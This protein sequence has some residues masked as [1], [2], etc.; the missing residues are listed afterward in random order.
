MEL[1]NLKV[2]GTLGTE[3][4]FV[5]CSSSSSSG[6]E[7]QI[8]VRQST[9]QTNNSN[10]PTTSSGTEQVRVWRD[11]SLILESEPNVRHIHSVQHQ[12]LLMSHVPPVSSS[13]AGNAAAAAALV[14]HYPPPPPPLI[15][16]PHLPPHALPPHLAPPPALYSQLQ[17]DVLW[18]HQRYPPLPPVGAHL[19]GPAGAPPSAEELLERERAY[20]QDRE[21]ILR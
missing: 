2:L 3:L 4:V 21:R 15:T 18:K 10:V 13:A 1:V 16:H 14:G 12:S 7:P 11:P 6:T 17:H 8:T 9:A 20:N 5:L 19:L